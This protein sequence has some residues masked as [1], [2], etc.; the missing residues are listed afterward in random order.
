MAL[1]YISCPGCGALIDPSSVVD[2]EV[3]F[4]GKCISQGGYY[5]DRKQDRDRETLMRNNKFREG[6]S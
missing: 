1:C 6:N 4:C 2:G 3:V 5:A